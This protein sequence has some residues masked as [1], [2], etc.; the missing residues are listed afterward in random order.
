MPNDHDNIKAKWWELDDV[1]LA[2]SVF[3]V[4]RKIESNQT[5]RNVDNLRYFKMYHNSEVG[6]GARGRNDNLVQNRVALNIVQSCVDTAT[7]KIAK[8]KP[9][10]MFLTD[11]GD[12]SQQR[13]GKLLT[14]YVEGV[15]ETAKAYPIGQR[16]FVDSCVFGTGIMKVFVDRDAKSIKVERVFVDEIMVDDNEGI[17]GEPRQMHQRQYISRDKLCE[18][19][20]DKAEQIKGAG[21]GSFGRQSDSL[22]MAADQCI[23]LESWHLRSGR[24][25][26]DGKHAIVL[27]GVCLL[28]E[29]YKKDYFPFVVIRWNQKLLGFFGMGLAEQLAGIQ[30]EINKMLRNIQI[31]QHLMCVPRVLIENSSNVVP[32]HFNNEIGGMIKYSGIKPEVMMAPAMSPEV[33]Q[34]LENLYKKAY[35]IT[36]IS[37]LSASSR[38]PAGLESAVALREFQDIE[39][40]RFMIVG[41]AWEQF[42]MDLARMVI[43][44]SRDLYKGKDL[45]MVK[46]KKFIQQIPWQDVDLEDDQFVMKVFPVNGLPQTPAGKLQKVVE[47]FQNGLIEKNEGIDLL[48]WPDF[49][50]WQSL[51]NAALDD[52]KMLIENMLVDGEYVAPSI[53]M[54][55]ELAKGLAH[56][57]L[58]RAMVRKKTPE[59]NLQLLRTFIDEI[60]AL[61]AIGAQSQQAAPQAPVATPPPP[62]VGQLQPMQ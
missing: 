51:H 48:D 43:D 47:M 32:A 28:S 13:K 42:Y 29:E 7:A 27:D 18:M 21:A 24:D 56:S 57:S 59:Q 41:Q 49:E 39:T 9:R 50:E 16:C 20:P 40:E 2:N 45:V 52:A 12:F 11:E 58:L 38:K 33:Y 55:L 8:N 5:Y 14:K 30:F 1:S 3:A 4:A 31:A 62:P 37:M 60:V 6:I 35:E 34:H 26:N 19:F 36:G 44:M 25:A 23:V 15:Y 17:Y 54:D 53:Y 22:T 46:G 10:P 61:Q